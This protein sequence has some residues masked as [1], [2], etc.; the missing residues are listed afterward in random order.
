MPKGFVE[1]TYITVDYSTL[2]QYLKEQFPDTWAEF[3]CDYEMS[4]DTYQVLS[5][6][7]EPFD[8]EYDIKECDDI[9]AGGTCVYGASGLLMQRLCQQGILPAGEYLVEVCW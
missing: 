5:V 2:D 7:N 3:L 4:N 9:I 1:K 8:D 6:T